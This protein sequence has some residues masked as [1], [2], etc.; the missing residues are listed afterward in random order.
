MY[1]LCQKQQGEERFLW[2]VNVYNG[3]RLY[4]V[5][6]WKDY[7][8]L[9]LSILVHHRGLKNLRQWLVFSANKKGLP[10]CLNRHFA[11]S[12]KPSSDR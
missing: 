5:A 1:R 7:I 12:L 3:G 6:A 4:V 9:C 8:A 11:N 2:V 10:G